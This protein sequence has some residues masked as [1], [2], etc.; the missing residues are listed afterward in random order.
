MTRNLD[1]VGMI[2]HAQSM[3]RF[4]VFRSGWGRSAARHRAPSGTVGDRGRGARFRLLATMV[5]RD[6]LRNPLTGLSMLCMFVVIMAVYVSMWFAFMVVGPGPTVVLHPADGDVAAALTAAGVRVVDG[7]AQQHNVQIRLDGEEALVVLDSAAKPA[8]NP[9][10][11]GLRKAGIAPERITVVDDAG[12]LKIDPLRTFLGAAA[13]TGIASA[14]F[15]GLTVPVVSMRERGLLRLFG[16]TPLRR[17]TFLLAQLPAR[18]IIIG[19]EVA[20]IVAIAVLRRYVDGLDVL[21][22]A[23]TVTIGSVMLTALALAFAARSRNAEATQQGMVML[24]LMLVFASGGLLPPSIVPSGVQFVMNTLPTAWF[25][26]AM[27][28]DLTATVPFVPVPVLWGLMSVV[29]CC[30]FVLAAKRFHWDAAEQRGRTDTE[31]GKQ[32]MA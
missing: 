30:G 13:L 23:V 4:L 14:V 27:N 28:A 18:A 22:F 31:Q 21:R 2:L 25:A 3:S 17:S 24:T 16:T 12:D 10:W 26:A 9:I 6:M 19:L 5:G 8:W 32:V 15:I 1:I 11:L 7:E 29:A 20:I